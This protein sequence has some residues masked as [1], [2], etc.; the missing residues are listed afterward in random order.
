MQDLRVNGE[1]LWN[2]LMEMAQFGLTAKGGCN[3][4]AAT[5]LDGKARDLFVSWCEACV[6]N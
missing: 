6:E 1:R 3:R 5:E 2:S 4:L